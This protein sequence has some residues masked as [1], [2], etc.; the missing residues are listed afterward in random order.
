[1]E[2][3]KGVAEW[4]LAGRW[5]MHLILGCSIFVFGITIERVWY[6]M[7]K[8]SIKAEEFTLEIIKHI[9]K[10]D[11][12]GAISVAS[13]YDT[14]LSRIT[15]VALQ[16]FAEGEDD[17]RELQTA[18]DEVSLIEIPKLEKRTPYLQ[19]LGNISVLFGLLGT[20]SGLIAAFGSLAGVSAAEK[21]AILSAGIS[22]AMHCT[23]FGL[24]IAITSLIFHGIIAGRTRNILSDLD[25]SIVKILNTL[26]EIRR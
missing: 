17:P 3:L 23:A 22:E 21:T 24:A 9:K 10:R 16:A 4:Y 6:V 7:V 2:F 11:I 19:M 8:S 20:I 13:R 15:L 26:E 5:G 12:S 14:P 25:S 1:M 18:V